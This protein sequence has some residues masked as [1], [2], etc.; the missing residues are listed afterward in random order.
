[1]PLFSLPCGICNSAFFN[2]VEVCYLLHPPHPYT[3]TPKEVIIKNITVDCSKYRSNICR[4]SAV[5]IATESLLIVL[6][7]ET[8]LNAT[9]LITQNEV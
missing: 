1:M 8:S 9:C 3:H 5:R 2:Y 4:E 7:A 6:V